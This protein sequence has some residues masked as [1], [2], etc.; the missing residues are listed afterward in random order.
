MSSTATQ[1]KLGFKFGRNGV[2]SSR[3]MMLAEISELF[4][5]RPASATAAQYKEDIEV[6]NVLHK[7]TEKSRQ[8]TWRHLVD[9]YGM[10]TDIPLFR[11]FRRLWDS[12]ESARTLLACQYLYHPKHQQTNFDT[13]VT[14][15]HPGSLQG[16]DCMDQ[17]GDGY[18]TIKELSR[19]NDCVEDAS[20][21][22]LDSSTRTT[23]I[24]D[25]LDADRDL[26]VSK[27]EFSIWNEMQKQ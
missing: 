23:L 15:L 24:L 13:D 9:L 27:R 25:H 12:D 5:G 3:T 16:F 18:L 26:K 4:H 10:D 1:Q 14:P 19:R 17:N 7:P 11:V 21:R 2:H 22:G 8:L 6:F 20:D